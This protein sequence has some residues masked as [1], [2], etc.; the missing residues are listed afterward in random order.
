M[1]AKSLKW[2]VLASVLFI[3]STANASS[4]AVDIS[5]GEVSVPLPLS[6]VT[7]AET[8]TAGKVPSTI[9]IDI[10]KLNKR[11]ISIPP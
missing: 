4:S 11:F 7:S 1:S 3:I 2:A 6:D 9:A 10:K 8:I 5:Y